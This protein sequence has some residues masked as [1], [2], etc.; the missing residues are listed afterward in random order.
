MPRAPGQDAAWP[1][2]GLAGLIV[3]SIALRGIAADA[4]AAPQLLCDEFIHAAESRGLWREGHYA[5]REAAAAPHSLFLPVATIPAQ[6]AGSGPGVYAALKATNVLAVSFV[7]VPV[8]LI[9]RRLMRPGWALVAAALSAAI[10]GF[11]FA[12]LIM[13]EPAFFAA[14]ALALLLSLRAVETPTGSRQ[15]LALASVGLAAAI[16]PQGAVLIVALLAAAPLTAAFEARAGGRRPTVRQLAASL[17]RFRLT[18]LLLLAASLLVPLARLVEGRSPRSALGPYQAVL[19]APL[20][21]L[22]LAESAGLHLAFLPLSVVLVPVT[23]LALM[24]VCAWSEGGTRD[25]SERAFIALALTGLGTTLAV[26]A[27]FAAA[28][29]EGQIMERYA[30]SMAPALMI[31]FALWLDRGLPRPRRVTPVLAAVP[32][33]LIAAV[34]FARYLDSGVPLD[35]PSAMVFPRI[36]DA[37]G[38]GSLGLIVLA[39]AV[40]AVVALLVAAAPSRLARVALPVAVGV[41]LVAGSVAASDQIRSQAQFHRS[42]AGPSPTWIDDALDGEGDVTLLDISP[43]DDLPDL[44]RDG[45]LLQAEFWNRSVRRVALSGDHACGLPARSATLVDDSG[46][47]D[48]EGGTTRNVVTYRTHVLAGERLATAGLMALTRVDEPLRLLASAEGVAAD[49]WFGERATIRVNR[50]IGSAPRSL[51]LD[52][53][54]PG[55]T[56]SA[57]P[58]PVRVAVLEGDGSTGRELAVATTRVG[59]GATRRI[60]VGLPDRPS[61]VVIEA[62]SAFTLEDLGF[63][64]PIPGR[65]FGARL[66]VRVEPT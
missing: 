43:P 46:S 10:P 31:A 17:L 29:A 53:D 8:F 5:F 49:A 32:V 60:R 51:A 18:I 12:G 36:A 22:G 1:L 40:G 37:L 9:A 64:A 27:G 48:V 63:P 33:A 6:A 61:T 41:A 26:A 59:A 24:T 14:V 57:A 45:M 42:L 30:F 16:R 13:T 47:V 50:A 3:V 2:I 35:T 66:D 4:V 23:A 44:Q 39:L 38:L 55:W 21:P 56:H 34:P 28:F 11:A 20:E 58:T 52:L 19:D 15:L 25:R 65:R 54:R 7:A 62:A